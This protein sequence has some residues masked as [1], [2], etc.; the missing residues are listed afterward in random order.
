VTSTPDWVV[1]ALLLSQIVLGVVVALRHSW[2]STWFAAVAAPYFWSLVRLNP[3]M[4][5]VASLPL[6]A[7]AHLIGAYLLIL[8][9]PFSRLVHVLVVP[10]PYLWRPPQVVRWHRRAPGIAV[11]HGSRA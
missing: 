6:L 3:D 11:K 8:V 4:A 1:Y 10:N 7:R 2:G 9:F 5:A